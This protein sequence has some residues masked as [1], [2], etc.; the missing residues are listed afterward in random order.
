MTARTGQW[1][2]VIRG[3]TVRIAYLGRTE[4]TGHDYVWI[5]YVLMKTHIFPNMFVKTKVF[6]NL[7]AKYLNCGCRKSSFVAKVNPTRLP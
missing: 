1:G 5:T 4:R 3:R 7:F 6:V 2:W